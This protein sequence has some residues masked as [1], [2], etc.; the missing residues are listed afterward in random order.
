MGQIKRS[1]KKKKNKNISAVFL[2]Q[3]K[4]FKL[5][6]K[7]T[8]ENGKLIM[9]FRERENKRDNRERRG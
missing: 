1:D 5:K 7:K 8:Q 9:R 4:K 2:K 6:E 3:S